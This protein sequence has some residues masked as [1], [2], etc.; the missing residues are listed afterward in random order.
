MHIR[1]TL[2][3]VPQPPSNFTHGFIQLNAVK[4]YVNASFDVVNLWRPRSSFF[5]LPMN[6]ACHVVPI[7]IF[8]YLR[9]EKSLID[10]KS[11]K[12]GC[13]RD[14]LQRLDLVQ[15]VYTHTCFTYPL[16]VIAFIVLPF[17]NDL[18][19][20]DTIAIHDGEF[21]MALTFW[22]YESPEKD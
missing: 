11:C 10:P 15:N 6:T 19:E 13:K 12:C 22:R 4:C 8:R 1:Y 9:K 20:E 2:V 14:W 18:K 17:R 3:L 16:N 21:V 5:Y 7:H